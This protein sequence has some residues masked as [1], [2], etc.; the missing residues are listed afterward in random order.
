M[1]STDSPMHGVETDNGIE[2]T[3]AMERLVAVV[4]AMGHVPTSGIFPIYPS[5]INLLA[6]PI[7]S[8]SNCCQICGFPSHQSADINNAYRCRTA[9]TTVIFFWESAIKDIRFLY[10]NHDKFKEAVNK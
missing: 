8:T 1:S 5:G 7:T 9:I 4:H 3:G 6:Q 10:H 2:V